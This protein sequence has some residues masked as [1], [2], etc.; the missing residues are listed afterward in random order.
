MYSLLMRKG[1][2]RFCAKSVSVRI[3]DSVIGKV[4][5]ASLAGY[6]VPWC[7]NKEI[8]KLFLKDIHNSKIQNI[9]SWGSLEYKPVSNTVSSTGIGIEET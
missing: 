8:N 3:H 4:E 7:D 6:F 2:E 5:Y 9:A 1:V